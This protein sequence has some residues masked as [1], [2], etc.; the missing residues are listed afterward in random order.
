M[1]ITCFF[2]VRLL[3]KL[4]NKL[5]LIHIWSP[6]AHHLPYSVGNWFHTLYDVI[7]IVSTS[8]FTCST[9]KLMEIPHGFGL[10]NFVIRQAAQKTSSEGWFRL[11]AKANSF[12]GHCDVLS[13]TW[14]W[15]IQLLLIF[16]HSPKMAPITLK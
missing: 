15:A 3:H 9:S 1:N 14:G 7:I 16:W 2:W 12:W 8:G 13:S 4:W 6:H 11:G 10:L 5:A